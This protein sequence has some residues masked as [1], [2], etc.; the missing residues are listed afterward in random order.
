M[1]QQMLSSLANNTLILNDLHIDDHD[2]SPLCRFLTS[3]NVSNLVDLFIYVHLYEFVTHVSY[4]LLLFVIILQTINTLEVLILN[5]S[6]AKTKRLRRLAA[7][8]AGSHSGLNLQGGKILKAVNMF[9]ARSQSLHFL[10]VDNV[11]LSLPIIHSM[12]AAMS[13]RQES[14]TLGKYS[15]RLFA[16]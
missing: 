15:R 4:L 14:I 2:I 1:S 12:G 10:E 9:I 6:S 7:A 13:E 16:Y 3:K 8:R 11:N 5:Q